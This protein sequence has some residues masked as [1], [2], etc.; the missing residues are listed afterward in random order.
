M[1]TIILQYVHAGL[2]VVLFGALYSL[3]F[4]ALH[5]KKVK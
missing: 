2:W 4:R 5:N 3:V 1:S